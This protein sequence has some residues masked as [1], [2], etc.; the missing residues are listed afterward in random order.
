MRET[1]NKIDKLT[2]KEYRKHNK[3]ELQESQ[4][5]NES[6]VFWWGA[7]IFATILL[8]SALVK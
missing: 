8:I 5:S 3:Q 6:N 7:I 2:M 1:E 4:E